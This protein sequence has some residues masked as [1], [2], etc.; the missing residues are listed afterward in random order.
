MEMFVEYKGTDNGFTPRE[1]IGG[2]NTV[3][4]TEPTDGYKVKEEQDDWSESKHL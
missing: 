2:Q 4:V 3:E 1:Y